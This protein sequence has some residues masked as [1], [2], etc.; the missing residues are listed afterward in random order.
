[1]NPIYLIL[2]LYLISSFLYI[3]HLWLQNSKLPT[4]GF[5]IGITGLIL[6]TINLVRVFSVPDKFNI[7][8]T[9][10]LF[11][12]SWLIGIVFIVS[13]IKFKAIILGA[14]ILPI[15]LLLALPSLIIPPGIINDDLS[16]NNP[17]ILAHILLIFLGEAIFVISFIAGLLYIFQESKIKSKKVSRFLN[18]FPSLITL[19]K[20]NHFTLL[21]G[22][23]FLTIGLAIG[24]I[25]AK[26]ILGEDWIWGAKE[27]LSSVTWLLY[28]FLINGRFSSGW[29][30]KKSAT[31]AIVGFVIIL[32]IFTIGYILPGF[33]N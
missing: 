31:G 22:F 25:L 17:W 1:M 2:I 19:D 30:G 13:Q 29:K 24:F 21:L 7:G 18:K 33:D 12:F 14:F 26:E 3:T 10:T 5:Y 6:H 23:P 32:I 27:T 16:L 4:Y 11:I 9:L 8:L 20:I 28:A 15:M